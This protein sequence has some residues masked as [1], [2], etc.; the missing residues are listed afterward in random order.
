MCLFM[1]F[2]GIVVLSEDSNCHFGETCIRA[3]TAIKPECPNDRRPLD[4]ATGLTSYTVL[5][6]KVWALRVKCHIAPD[7]CPVTGEM[8]KDE[9]RID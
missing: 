9:V 3:A 2:M 6:R 8:G 7:Q 5:A 1:M 4:P